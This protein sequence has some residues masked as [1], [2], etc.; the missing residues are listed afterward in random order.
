[1]KHR[2]S[3]VD[4]VVCWVLNFFSLI[5][6]VQVDATVAV[7]RTGIPSHVKA[8]AAPTRVKRLYVGRVPDDASEGMRHAILI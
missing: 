5:P 7:P 3:T 2:K 1:M 6:L 4:V 8:G